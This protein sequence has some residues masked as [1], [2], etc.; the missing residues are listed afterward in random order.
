MNPIYYSKFYAEL[1]IFI[2]ILYYCIYFFV[3]K[4]RAWGLILLGQKMTQ[5]R[6]YE[7]K[8]PKI[9]ASVFL[10]TRFLMTRLKNT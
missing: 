10:M 6:H 5:L 1:N 2:T 9:L 3:R 7:I 8:I 4:M